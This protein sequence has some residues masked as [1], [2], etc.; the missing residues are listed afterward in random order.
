MPPVR[1]LHQ[2]HQRKQRQHDIRQMRQDQQCG[3]HGHQLPR[4]SPDRRPP[5]VAREKAPPEKAEAGRWLSAAQAQRR[6]RAKPTRRAKLSAHPN[7]GH[8]T[9]DAGT[10]GGGGDGGRGGGGETAHTQ[11][12]RNTR[13]MWNSSSPGK[14]SHEAVCGKYR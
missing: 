3:R 1:G 8:V 14:Q 6:E 13:A 4:S 5:R 11:P 10:R 7:G 9:A 2:R 12:M